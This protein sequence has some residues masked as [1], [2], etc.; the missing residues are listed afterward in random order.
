MATT[1]KSQTGRIREDIPFLK[2]KVSE[3]KKK[4]NRFN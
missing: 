2:N 1:T 4:K 3:V